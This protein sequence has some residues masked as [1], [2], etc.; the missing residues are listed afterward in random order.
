MK[1][2]ILPVAGRSSRFPNMRPKW[3]LTLPSGRIMLEESVN[4]LDVSRFD[5]IIVTC[6]SEHLDCHSNSESLVHSLR[7]NIR[8]DVEL[9]ILSEPTNSHAE[10]IY[11]TIK[12][13]DLIGSVYLKDCDNSFKCTPVF[14][15][16]IAT[17]S[18]NKVDLIDAKNKSYVQLDELGIVQNIVEKEVISSEFCCGGYSFE[19][20]SDFLEAYERVIKTGG[21]QEVYVSHIIYDLLLHG[22]I[23]RT[24]QVSDY[25]DW[26]TLRE[27]RHAQ[28]KSM[29][30][31]CDVDGVLLINSSKFAEK[32]WHIEPIKQNVD[33]I[34]E[35]Q[36]DHNLYLVIT[37]SRPENE[38]KRLEQFFSEHGIEVHQFVFGLP[39]C[40]RVIV[41]D[42]SNTNLYPSAIA[43]NITRDTNTLKS[44]LEHLIA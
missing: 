26:G 28:R 12:R 2:L 21:G 16:S 4:K 42:F 11:E 29:T 40:K 19:Q 20:S 25:I 22:K 10:T 41:N 36:R 38:K 24:H 8:H 44:Y 30:L 39:H 3:L 13:S 27:F 35:L 33:I 9:C 5:R 43:I 15:N 7:Q 17:V 32:K 23:F 6:L 34:K 31:F 14:E 1:S 18:L 37:T